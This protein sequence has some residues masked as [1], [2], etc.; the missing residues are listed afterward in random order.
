M[1]QRY[2]WKR[3]WLPRDKAAEAIGRGFMADPENTV[4]GIF[5]PTAR[6]LSALTQVKCL[7]LLGEPGLGKSYSVED[8][9]NHEQQVYARSAETR[10]IDLK[11]CGDNYSLD[12]EIFKA[13]W[14]R[15]WE[16]VNAGVKI[17]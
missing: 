13:D 11:I 14:F 6:T 2:D 9:F 1:K 12:Q 8:A 7:V 4:G 10:L 5:N 3:F 15:A 16:N 17:R